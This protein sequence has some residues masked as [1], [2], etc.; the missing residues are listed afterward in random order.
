[1]FLQKP[2]LRSFHVQYNYICADSLFIN[3]L[4]QWMSFLMMAAMLN[5][6]LSC[7][8]AIHFSGGKQLKVR[9]IITK[10]LVTQV[11]CFK[12]MEC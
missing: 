10:T 5:L 12:F 8:L 4:K 7:K 1:M 9:E 3:Y 2:A 11:I 6:L